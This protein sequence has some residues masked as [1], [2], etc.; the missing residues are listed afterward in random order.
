MAAGLINRGQ[1][2][3]LIMLKLK[4]IKTSTMIRGIKGSEIVKVVQK[5]ADL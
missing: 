5:Q 1:K 2:K 3:F 4:K